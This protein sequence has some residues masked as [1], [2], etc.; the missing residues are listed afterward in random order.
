M[1]A[2]DSGVEAQSVNP[3]KGPMSTEHVAGAL[4]LGALVLLWLIGRGFRGVAVG[5]VSVGVK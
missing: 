3:I 4:V 2:D 5:G 1:Y